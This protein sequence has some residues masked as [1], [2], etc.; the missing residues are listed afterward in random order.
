MTFIKYILP[1]FTIYFSLYSLSLTHTHICMHTHTHTSLEAVNESVF[2]CEKREKD[3]LPLGWC[4]D[5]PWH[6]HVPTSTPTLALIIKAKI[7]AANQS[8]AKQP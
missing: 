3:V 1:L 5:E 6:C 2:A 7:S 4:L 8:K